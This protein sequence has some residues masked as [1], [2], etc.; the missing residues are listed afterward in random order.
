MG[1]NKRYHNREIVSFRIVLACERAKLRVL[2][3]RCCLL[4]RWLEKT[5]KVLQV[6]VGVR[7]RRAP[8]AVHV[9]PPRSNEKL[10]SFRSMLL[11]MLLYA[12]PFKCILLHDHLCLET[13]TIMLKYAGMVT[14]GVPFEENRDHQLHEEKGTII[15]LYQHRHPKYHHHL[16]DRKEYSIPS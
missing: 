9:R 12:Q 13:G 2:A 1:V 4:Q 15:Y 11:V 7:V 3:R 14:E 6:G 10:V 16:Q 8:C 5:R